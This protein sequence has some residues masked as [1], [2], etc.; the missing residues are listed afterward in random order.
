MQIYFSCEHF[1]SSRR[2]NKTSETSSLFLLRKLFGP[3][4][5][6]RV[7]TLLVDVL[8]W[9]L[10]SF[11]DC[12]IVY[13]VETN[14]SGRRVYYNFIYNFYNIYN[15]HGVVEMDRRSRTWW[16]VTRQAVANEC[17]G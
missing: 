3:F 17:G 12:D 15:F 2:N 10:I 5:K 11:Y 4:G 13:T 9:N 16:L 8:S 7:S 1:H 14:R 6:I